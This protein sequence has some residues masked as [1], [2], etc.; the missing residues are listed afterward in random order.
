MARWATLIE[1]RRRERPVM[2]IDA[3]DFC[4]AR[5]KRNKEIDDRYFFEALEML[6]YEAL[7]AAENEILFGRE[8]LRE[9]IEDHGLAV[10]SA[11]ILD[12]KTG[13]PAFE[14]YVIRQIG[15]SRFLFFRWGGI[16][17]GF[18]SVSDPDLVYGADRLVKDYYEVIDPRIAALDAVTELRQRGCD[19]IVASSHQEWD[20]SVEFAREV[21]GINIVIASHSSQQRA[22]STD[23]EGALVV[24]P[25]VNRT[26]FTELEATWS[27]DG[28]GVELI[29]WQEKLLEVADH[30]D[31]AELEKKYTN[32]T[33]DMERPDRIR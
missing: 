11:N 12:R 17:V 31:F 3:G 22:R 5:K 29:D 20:R 4:S 19:V 13:E 10:V 14:R 16:K 15:G 32:E 30:P 33:R 26:S 21:P 9:M 18:F 8:N 24:A 25:G 7:G 27:P 2:L 28:T 6:G 23:V 1:E